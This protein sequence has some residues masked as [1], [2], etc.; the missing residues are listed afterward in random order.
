MKIKTFSRSF[1][2]NFFLTSMLMVQPSWQ[3]RR[4][5]PHRGGPPREFPTM[6]G[7]PRQDTS[8]ENIRQ[9]KLFSMINELNMIKMQLNSVESR[10]NRID[11]VIAKLPTR[12]ASLRQMNYLLHSDLEENQLQ[13]ANSWASLSPLVKSEISNTA[14]TIRSEI[15]FL[16][17]EINNSRMSSSFDLGGLSRLEVRINSQR[18]LVND[19][20]GR[21][22]SQLT[23][24]DSILTPIEQSLVSAE[25]TVKLISSAS[26]KWK[27]GET[28]VI[29][30]PAKDMNE[31]VEGVLTLTNQR[32][33]YESEK[34]V[35]LKKTL[36]IV[37][38]KKIERQTS[39]DKPIGSVKNITKG[40]VGL[41]AGAGIYVTF[42]DDDKQL[43]LDV[44]GEQ[45]D[46]LTK[47]Y[48]L[49]TSGQIDV[50]LG[51]VMPKLQKPTEKKLITC[52]K[53]GAPYTDE[54]Y[55]GQ[56]TVQCKYCGTRITTQ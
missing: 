29:S 16:E 35:V 54:V 43:K 10:V 38:E 20:S 7:V 17:R 47:Y 22:Q 19:L 44:T 30:V 53:C 51:K 13:A 15:S 24:F 49:I 25:S 31:N 56:L 50:D 46:E 33:L 26:F 2:Q 39:I 1:I 23:P 27:E 52:P 40:S 14:P 8:S 48:G 34:E 55:R 32:I 42:K 6:G 5:G 9:Q 11:D 12:I 37:T 45:A 21:I 36:F 4:R 41:L 18:A 28:P 3:D